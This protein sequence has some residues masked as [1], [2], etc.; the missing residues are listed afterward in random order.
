MAACKDEDYSETYLTFLNLLNCEKWRAATLD[1]EV[2]DCEN[3]P[4]LIHGI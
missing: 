3:P 4:T 2:G 1:R